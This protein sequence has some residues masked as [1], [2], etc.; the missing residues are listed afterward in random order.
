[1]DTDACSYDSCYFRTCDTCG[2]NGTCVC[3]CF[4][5]VYRQNNDAAAPCFMRSGLAAEPAWSI[6]RYCAAAGLLG[7]AAWVAATM[8]RRRQSRNLV[9]ASL[10]AGLVLKAVD[11]AWNPLAQLGDDALNPGLFGVLSY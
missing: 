9:R 2:A 3:G 11:L 6:V 8:V 7:T 4:N 5:D 10:L 1:M